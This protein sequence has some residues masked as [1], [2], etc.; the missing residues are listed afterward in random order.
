M[1]GGSE[2]APEHERGGRLSLKHA[3]A[4]GARACW[5]LEHAR[6]T[7]VEA[8]HGSFSWSVGGAR[9]ETRLAAQGRSGVSH[10]LVG[11]IITLIGHIGHIG[12]PLCYLKALLSKPTK[13]IEINLVSLVAQH[14]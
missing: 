11:C 14:T 12:S 10:V 2:Q 6:A 7:G 4:I 1:V 9:E 5:P 3:L 8:G 13:K